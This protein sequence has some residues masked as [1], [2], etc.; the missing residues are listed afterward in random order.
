M[1]SYY[2]M[3]DSLYEYERLHEKFRKEYTLIANRM[4][5]YGFDWFVESQNMELLNF[6]LEICNEWQFL[7][8]SSDISL[9]EYLKSIGYNPESARA[10]NEIAI[11]IIKEYIFLKEILRKDL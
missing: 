4:T 8:S 11:N 7:K 1:N 10:A 3:V 9:Y 6:I 5:G 2:N